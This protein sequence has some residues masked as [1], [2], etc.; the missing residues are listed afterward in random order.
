[1]VDNCMISDNKNIVIPLWQSLSKSWI[2]VQI[3]Y[4]LKKII[5]RPGQC[6]HNNIVTI[7]PIFHG[8]ATE[9]YDIRSILSICH[10]IGYDL[11]LTLILFKCLFIK[12]NISSSKCSFD[13]GIFRGESCAWIII[14]SLF[15]SSYEEYATL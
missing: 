8:I 4:I 11:Y 15:L 1:M 7:L 14:I 5:S 12:S 13:L 9:K 6:W 3:V 10:D 2:V